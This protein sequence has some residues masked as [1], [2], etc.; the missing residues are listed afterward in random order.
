MNKNILFF[1]IAFYVCA[2][3]GCA[4]KGPVAQKL[5]IQNH[6][7]TIFAVYLDSLYI[8]ETPL[9]Q[10]ILPD[11]LNG[12]QLRIK[13]KGVLLK[14][15][16]LHKDS[17]IEKIYENQKTAIALGTVAG[18]AGAVLIPY[19]IA[20]FAPLISYIPA[21]R[22]GNSRITSRWHYTFTNDS[23]PEFKY[24]PSFKNEPVHPIKNRW[25]IIKQGH[26]VPS[27]TYYWARNKNLIQSSD[28]CYDEDNKTVWFASDKEEKIFFP[29]PIQH[30]THCLDT[31]AIKKNIFGSETPIINDHTCG[32][33]PEPE[34]NIEWF[35]QYPCKKT[36][37]KNSKTDTQ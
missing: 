34:K 9:S 35:R 17:I 20:V 36:L 26:K 8:G 22:F 11:T 24:Y 13:Y 16:E 30:A 2:L 32:Y 6:D 31:V 7:E 14:T 12:V 29:I 21:M 25:F 18:I 33:L 15:Y 3:L 4:G 19:P 23:F 37:R 28:I 5:Q 10:D 1:L 27:T